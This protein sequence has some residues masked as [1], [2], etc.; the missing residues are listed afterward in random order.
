MTG[1]SEADEIYQMEEEQPPLD[2][3][4][5]DTEWLEGLFKGGSDG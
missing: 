3:T 2:L 1:D 4:E 5:H